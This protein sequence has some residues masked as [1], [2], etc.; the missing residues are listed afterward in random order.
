MNKPAKEKLLPFVNKVR[1]GVYQYRHPSY[2]KEHGKALTFNLKKLG[3]TFEDFEARITALNS[4]YIDEIKPPKSSQQSQPKVSP[5]SGVI[6]EASFT[7]LARLEMGEW[8]QK[9]Q[10]RERTIEEASRHYAR[11]SDYF[12]ALPIHGILTPQIDEF[13]LK[14]KSPHDQRKFLVILRRLYSFARRRGSFP[15]SFPNPCDDI[16]LDKLP[17]TE[18]MPLTQEQFDAVFAIAPDWMQVAMTIAL[19]TS[20]R[21]SDILSL[22]FTDINDGYLTVFPSKS[23]QKIQN[24]FRIHSKRL[25]FDL[26]AN[27]ELA[28]AIEKGRQIV[29]ELNKKGR[30]YRDSP[31]IVSYSSKLRQVPSKKK[32]HPMQITKEIASHSFKKLRDQVAQTSN[33]FDGYLDHEQGGFHG[34]R[35]LSLDKIERSKGI[36]AARKRA[37]HTSQKMTEHYVAAVDRRNVV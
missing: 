35:K 31:F 28:C 26:A 15:P 1:D 17:P 7:Q 22:R 37:G 23:Q 10:P 12:G 14:V 8:I 3:I 30:L 5:P 16:V 29:E 21:L 27:K 34:I 9:T 19:E 2:V 6:S 25:D 13:F 11:L 20:L 32:D 24:R 33:V 18:R 4:Q 36:E